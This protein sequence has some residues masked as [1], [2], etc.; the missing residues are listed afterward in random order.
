MLCL[1]YLLRIASGSS[2]RSI[3]LSPAFIRTYDWKDDKNFFLK[4][5]LIKMTKE[6]YTSFKNLLSFPKN[7]LEY[8]NS[9]NGSQYTSLSHEELS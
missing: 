6:A 2:M 7:N 5:N 3:Y 8:F 1:G 9:I 4:D